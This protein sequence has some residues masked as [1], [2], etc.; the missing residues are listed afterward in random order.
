MCASQEIDKC[1]SMNEGMR[2]G[3]TVQCEAFGYNGEDGGRTWEEP[4]EGSHGNRAGPVASDVEALPT[5]AGSFDGW[6]C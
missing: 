2:Q 4:R 5:A 1:S 6:G 3:F